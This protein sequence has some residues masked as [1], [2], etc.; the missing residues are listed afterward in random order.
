ME[1]NRIKQFC[2]IVETGSLTK[3]ADLLG[4]THGGLHKSLRVLENEL[5]F[6][7]TIG[8]GRGIEITESGREFY[9]SAL[10][11]LRAVEN[12][13]KK[14]KKNEFS[15]YKIGSLE[16]FLKHLPE[17]L[18]HSPTFLNRLV[19]F[20]EMSTGQL[21]VAVKNK[22]IDVGVTY[23]PAPTDGVEYLRIGKFRMGI[24]C[25]SEKLAN[26]TIEN[27]PFVVPS[28]S[29]V[30][31]PLDIHNSDGWKESLCLRKIAYKASSL[32]TAMEIVKVG[33]VAVYMPL[34][35]KNS[36]GVKLFEAKI[37]NGLDER[38]VFLVLP[39]NK[40]ESKEVKVIAKVIKRIIYGQ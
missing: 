12:G 8:K 33:P 17:N 35:L 20:Q 29:I 36:F 9:P 4:I 2:T 28:S 14:N 32:A 16:I 27:I 24:F 22:I 37:P 10:E 31:N 18:I 11:I 39:T 3:A 13:I 23:I 21:E 25:V 5:G 19:S 6:R 7:L 26:Q 38:D 30:L 34:F 40:E 15:E 1:T